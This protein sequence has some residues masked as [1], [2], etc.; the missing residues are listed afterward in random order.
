VYPIVYPNI[1]KLT[2]LKVRN[3]KPLDKDKAYCDGQGLYI[4][5]RTSGSK[6]WII[7][8]K[9]AG[10]TIITTI[11]GYPGISLKEARYKAQNFEELAR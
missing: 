1:G 9:Q 6:K 4:R 11:G 5:V 7:R 3:L 10:K 2:D 8:R